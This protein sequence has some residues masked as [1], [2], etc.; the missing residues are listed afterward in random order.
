MEIRFAIRTLLSCKARGRVI[1]RMGQETKH[2][3]G[4]S[5]IIRSLILA[6]IDLHLGT[7]GSIIVGCCHFRDVI[8][9]ETHPLLLRIDS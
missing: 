2:E 1:K 9:T 7:A 6:F 5:T 4:A 3:V 8:M